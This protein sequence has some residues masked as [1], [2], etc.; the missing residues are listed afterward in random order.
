MRSRP[1]K[2]VKLDSLRLMALGRI[3]RCQSCSRYRAL[4]ALHDGDSPGALLPAAPDSCSHQVC[5]PLVSR[6]SAQEPKRRSRLE[7]SEIRPFPRRWA[8]GS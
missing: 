2:T 8:T 7:A 3:Q 5:T 6:F 4:A 1:V